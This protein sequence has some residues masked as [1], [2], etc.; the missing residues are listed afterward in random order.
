MY[1][2]IC[3]NLTS[4][5][6]EIYSHSTSINCWWVITQGCKCHIESNDWALDSHNQSPIT[7]WTIFPPSS[8]RNIYCQRV[9]STHV[10]RMSSHYL[11]LQEVYITHVYR[12]FTIPMFTGSLQHPY[13]Q[14]EF[15]TLIFTEWVYNTHV[16]RMSLQHSQHSHWQIVYITHIYCTY[17][18]ES[19]RHPYLQRVYGTLIYRECMAP[20]FTESLQPLCLQVD[21]VNMVRK[22]SCGKIII[23]VPN[24]PR[25]HAI[26]PY[27]VFI[28]RQKLNETSVG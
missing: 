2:S 8:I 6:S 11:C 5:P 10:Y 9:Y 7:P 17:V 18:K 14:S 28:K 13:L 20:L 21:R 3:S 19:L 15:I 26:P 27:K 12:K 16:Y 25:R 23:Q 22:H 24:A 4:L 1:L